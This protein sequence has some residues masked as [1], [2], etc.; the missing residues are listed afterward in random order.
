MSLFYR[1][2]DAWA[3]KAGI[4]QTSTKKSATWMRALN[5]G[6]L[7]PTKDVGGIDVEFEVVRDGTHGCIGTIIKSKSSRE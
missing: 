1:D 2:I 4:K 3:I 5:E 6:L 7:I